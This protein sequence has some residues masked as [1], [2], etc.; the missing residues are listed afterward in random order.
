[1]V[2]IF[3]WIIIFAISMVPI[4]YGIRKSINQLKKE[5]R[6]LMILKELSLLYRAGMCE[7]ANIIVERVY[8]R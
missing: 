2:D 7:T 6:S 1:M 8:E 3:V 5:H 4:Y